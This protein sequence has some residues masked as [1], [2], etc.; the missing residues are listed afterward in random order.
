MV[1]LGLRSRGRGHSPTASLM[2]RRRSDV[3]FAGAGRRVRWFLRLRRPPPAPPARPPGWPTWAHTPWALLRMPPA[4]LAWPVPINQTRSGAR[5]T[6]NSI[7]CPR[8]SEMPCGGCRRLEQIVLVR[9]VRG[10]SRPGAW[11]RSSVLCSE[12]S[13]LLPTRPLPL[14]VRSAAPPFRTVM[15]RF[16][17]TSLVLPGV[18]R[19]SERSRPM[20]PCD[21]ATRQPTEWSSMPTWPSILE[22]GTID[23]TASPCS[24]TSSACAPSSTVGFRRRWRRARWHVRY[25]TVTT[26]R[27]C[28]EI[29]GRGSHDP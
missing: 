6:G 12:D 7:T 20:R 16:T 21:S 29:T 15:G 3:A 9:S 19:F 27:S 14:S 11:A 4:R 5:S 8:R 2:W 22:T 13:A 25:A 18:G 23:A 1:D 17:P 10:C 24:R 28:T 26:S